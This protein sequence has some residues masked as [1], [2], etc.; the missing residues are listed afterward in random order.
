[1][2]ISDSKIKARKFL[3]ID[4]LKRYHMLEEREIYI[5]NVT[6]TCDSGQS[7]IITKEAE[8]YTQIHAVVGRSSSSD[9]LVKHDVVYSYLLV[10]FL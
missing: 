5:S 2:S 4:L 7:L 8:I 10:S 1:M 6:V 3:Y 9:A